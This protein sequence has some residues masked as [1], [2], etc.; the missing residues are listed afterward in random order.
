MKQTTNFLRWHAAVSR[1]L[2]SAFICFAFAN[3]FLVCSNASA[4]T[5]VS[6][7][8]TLI[9]P[10]NPDF[11]TVLNQNFPDFQ[12]FDA[13]QKIRPFLAI[14]QNGTSYPV[15]AYS[16]VWE[17]RAPDGHIMRSQIHYIQKQFLPRTELRPF[18]PGETRLVSPYF[19]IGTTQYLLQHDSIGQ[20]ITSLVSNSPIMSQHLFTSVAAYI[21]GTIFEDGSYTGPDHFKLVLRYQALR[22]AERDEANSILPLVEANAPAS[23]IQ[24][25]LQQDADKGHTLRTVPGHPDRNTLYSLY[26]SREAQHLMIAYKNGGYTLLHRRTEAMANRPPKT[27]TPASAQSPQ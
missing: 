14:L 9:Q 11:D 6:R 27:L 1:A 25:L 5:P 13:Y 23:Q 22:D 18:R 15:A 21:D 8:L 2:C 7:L 24:N 26:R 3:A 4:Q 10:E 16:V 17:T 20:L 12:K 19:N